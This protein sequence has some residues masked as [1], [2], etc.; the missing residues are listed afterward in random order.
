[1]FGVT[2]HCGVW[3]PALQKDFT[4]PERPKCLFPD[5]VPKSG[6]A[7]EEPFGTC[8]T[9][10][11]LIHSLTKTHFWNIPGWD[12]RFREYR[13]MWGCSGCPRTPAV[14][15]TFPAG[16]DFCLSPWWCELPR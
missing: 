1:M 10:V 13:S 9:S 8:G 15:V 4:S 6:A 12:S 16:S 2:A 5:G 7:E 3:G 11:L 14:W